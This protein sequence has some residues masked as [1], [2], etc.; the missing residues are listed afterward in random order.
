LHC[1]AKQICIGRK[2]LFWIGGETQ[3][4][5][6]DE[7]HGGMFSKQLERLGNGTTHKDQYNS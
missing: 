5:C 3:V 2:Q 7:L 6:V 4:K 1:E